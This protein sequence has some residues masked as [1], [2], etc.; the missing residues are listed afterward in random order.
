MRQT[1]KVAGRLR[2]EAVE[3]SARDALLAAFRGWKRDA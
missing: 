1:L 2:E 3:P